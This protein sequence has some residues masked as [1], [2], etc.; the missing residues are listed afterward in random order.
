MADHSGTRN[1][2]RS[3]VWLHMILA[4]IVSMAGGGSIGNGSERARARAKTLGIAQPSEPCSS[5]FFTTSGGPSSSP[6]W[7]PGDRVSSK[8][9]ETSQRARLRKQT[10]AY[11]RVD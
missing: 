9:F 4:M 8:D 7:L 10:I 11:L 1:T 3:P 2:R 6:Y 5:S